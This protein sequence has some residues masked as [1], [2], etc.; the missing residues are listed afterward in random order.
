MVRPKLEISDVSAPNLLR[1]HYCYAEFPKLIFEDQ[2]V[3]CNLPDSIWITDTTFR[4]G[5]QARPPYRLEQILKIYD[6]LHK[7]D[8]GGGLIRQSEFFLYSQR[9]REA[10][11]ACLERGY[12]F[13]EVI[14][15]IRAK[16]SDL[17]Y[18]SQAG[19]RETGILMSVSDYHVFFKLGKTRRQAL[20]DYKAMVQLALDRH[21]IPR[22]HLE[23]I[24]RA[25]FD[26]FVLPL[27]DELLS[28]GQQA[29]VPLKIRLCDTLGLG[30]PYPEAALPRSVPKMMARLRSL[31]VPAEQ[32]EWHGH[33]DFHKAAVNGAAAWLYGGCSVNCS[34]LGVGERTGN[35]PLEALLVEQAQL[36]GTH[37]LVNY[38][39]L[40]ELAQWIQREMDFNIP[41]HYPLVGSNANVTCAGIHADGLAKHEEV[42]NAYDTDR[43]L[44]RPSRVD[45][46]DRSG[47]AGIAHWITRH[48]KIPVAKRD[49]RVGRLKQ[50]IDE[51]YA[52]GRGTFIS[53]QEMRTWV[54][55]VFSDM[56]VLR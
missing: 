51:V 49:P 27:V 30:V 5:Q 39:C 53:D 38:A 32:L 50:M 12:Q 20:E 15:W 33:N 10:V 2:S 26:G 31:G 9:D 41:Q 35:P 56:D 43:L 14:G 47:T 44:N 45:I 13:P 55:G 25:D 19:L 16:P 46:S 52:A 3:P 28:L 18:V 4:D 37:P 6:L 8:G 21:V 1:E 34:V 29:G 48:F 36:K 22:C 24:T 17:D 42:Y 40:G 11:S 7:I 23:D 54:Q